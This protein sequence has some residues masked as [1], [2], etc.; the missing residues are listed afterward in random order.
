MEYGFTPVT[1]F[2]TK[3][4][5]IE[6]SHYTEEDMRYIEVNA[7]RIYGD[8]RDSL[9][10]AVNNKHRHVIVCLSEEALYSSYNIYYSKNI[11][12]GLWKEIKKLSEKD[13]LIFYEIGNECSILTF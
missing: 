4:E 7:N 1:S 5:I 3:L 8:I 11:Y 13:E 10:S 12:S 6:S 2:K 9:L